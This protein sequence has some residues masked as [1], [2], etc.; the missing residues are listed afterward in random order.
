MIGPKNLDARQLQ[1]EHFF[2]SHGQLVA[3]I[4][5]VGGEEERK[6][7]LGELARLETGPVP[8]S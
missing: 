5:Q 4:E 3:V 1:A 8:E 6:E 2:T 7:Q